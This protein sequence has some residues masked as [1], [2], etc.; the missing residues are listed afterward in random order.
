MTSTYLC[1]RI[2]FAA[3]GE[4]LVK[5]A[6][7]L[8]ARLCADLA[9]QRTEV[10]ITGY[11]ASAK[12]VIDERAGSDTINAEISA[13]RTGPQT[14]QRALGDSTSIRVREVALT[15]DEAQAWARAEMLRRS[16]Q[17]VTVA[18][19]TRGSPDMVIGSRLTLS[20][21]GD[22]F[23]GDGYYAITTVAAGVEMEALVAVSTAALTIY[24]M[25]KSVDRAMVVEQIRLEEKSGGRSGHFVRSS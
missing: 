12:A 20:L 22:P 14:V 10:V 4:T 15:A 9:H 24:D 6:D 11:D 25:C 2:I 21:V 23:E 1:F 19:V 16:R 13:G 7:L 18:G 3:V 17:F 5:G 8:T